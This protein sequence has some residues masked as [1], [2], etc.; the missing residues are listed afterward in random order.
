MREAVGEL[1]LQMQWAQGKRVPRLQEEEVVAAVIAIPILMEEERV[2]V[3][4][5]VV[6]VGRLGL[7]P[8]K[9]SEEAWLQFLLRNFDKNSPRS[10]TTCLE[11]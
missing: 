1:E 2:A 8:G 11:P 6:V 7:F 9:S 5:V 10:T 3:A 4:M